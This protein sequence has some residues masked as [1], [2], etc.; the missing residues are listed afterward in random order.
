M[1][2]TGFVPL[3]LRCCVTFRELRNP[4]LD[5]ICGGPVIASIVLQNPHEGFVQYV[6]LFWGLQHLRNFSNI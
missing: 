3:Q 6:L 5:G 1:S 2:V 4:E